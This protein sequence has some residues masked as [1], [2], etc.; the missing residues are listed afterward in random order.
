M[1]Y[2]ELMEAFREEKPILYG[3]QVYPRISSIIT[4]KIVPGFPAIYHVI[5]LDGGKA[6]HSVLCED[7]GLLKIYDEEK[8]KEL[9]W[10]NHL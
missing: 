8:H 4:K 7:Y 1:Q 3:G 6:N 2:D 10:R 5:E 9:I